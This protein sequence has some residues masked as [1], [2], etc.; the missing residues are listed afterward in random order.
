[1]WKELSEDEIF[2]RWALVESW[3]AREKEKGEIP[4]HDI[5]YEDLVT[6][7]QKEMERLFSFLSLQFS[8]AIL[9]EAREMTV[10]HLKKIPFY[11]VSNLPLLAMKEHG[12]GA[13]GEVEGTISH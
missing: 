9:E 8:P 2:N 11:N 7:P 4:I 1:M 6:N 3:V 13:N 12:Y 10:G 5:R